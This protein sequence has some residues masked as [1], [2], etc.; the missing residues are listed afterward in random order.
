MLLFFF[1]HWS[2]GER[3]PEKA[4]P[5]G[6]ENE[7][8]FHQTPLPHEISEEEELAEQ[9]NKNVE[10]IGPTTK[11]PTEHSV[12]EVTGIRGGNLATFPSYF[13][14][15]QSFSGLW[16]SQVKEMTELKQSAKTV[17]SW[18]FVVLY[19]FS[20]HVYCVLL[21]TQLYTNYE[22]LNTFAFSPQEV[23]YTW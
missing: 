4:L 8:H 16:G 20:N 9:R 12:P 14:F 19:S 11:E 10:T 22:L 13:T 21:N 15:S 2:D 7:V 23:E 1:S 17:P 18:S 5:P 3:G 6:P